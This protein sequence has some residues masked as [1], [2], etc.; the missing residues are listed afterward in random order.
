MPFPLSLYGLFFTGHC[1]I[2]NFL[3]VISENATLAKFALWWPLRRLQSSFR[4]VSPPWSPKLSPEGIPVCG[5][6]H[7]V[8]LLWWMPVQG[9]LMSTTNSSIVGCLRNVAMV[10]PGL[11]NKVLSS[12]G[13]ETY[14]HTYIHHPHPI[15]AASVRPVAVEKDTYFPWIA[16]PRLG[17]QWLQELQPEQ[18]ALCMRRLLP[19]SLM[20]SGLFILIVHIPVHIMPST[21]VFQFHYNYIHFPI[22]KYIVLEY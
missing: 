7:Y 14:T 8:L 19:R 6:T 3:L 21:A 20:T 17:A 2:L 13:L 18:G 4:V 22:S 12:L 11:R 16:V 1:Q 9:Y 10:C 5:E 15:P